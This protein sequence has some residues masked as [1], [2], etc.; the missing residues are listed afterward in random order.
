LC[1]GV[2]FEA[3]GLQSKIHF[4]HCS[5]CRKCSGD[6]AAGAIIVRSDGLRW[7]AG[8]DLLTAGPKHAFCRVCGAPMP[9]AIARNTL[10][11]I[12]VGCLDDNPPLLVGEHVFVGSKAHWDVIGD[13]APQYEK[14]G[15]GPDLI[16]DQSS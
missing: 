4:C 6:S 12:P 1:G 9:D 5:R 10:Y 15:T 8:Q 2:R 11:E 14:G 3:T 16:L 13:D 7:L